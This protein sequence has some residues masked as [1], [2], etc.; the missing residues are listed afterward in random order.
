MTSGENLVGDGVWT[1]R[2]R[3]KK[4][5]VLYSTFIATGVPVKHGT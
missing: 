3:V 4:D 2:H 5:K 1:M